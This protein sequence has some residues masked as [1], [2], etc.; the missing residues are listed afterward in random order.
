MQNRVVNFLWA[1][2]TSV[3]ETV[4]YS[5]HDSILGKIMVAATEH[6]LSA[7]DFNVDK[8]QRQDHAIKGLMKKWPLAKLVES[9]GFTMRYAEQV[10]VMGDEPQP[11]TVHVFGSP[12]QQVVWQELAD[13][14]F[15]RT[16]TYQTIADNIGNP[17]AVRAVGSAVG[18]NPVAF[19]LPCHRVIRSDGEYGDYHWGKKLKHQILEWEQEQLQSY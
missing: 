16:V 4:Y 10:L 15:G 8:K 18:S 6:G 17:N 19:L 3:V 11:I 13:I 9:P 14:P 2:T 12:F 7:I 5:Q 1:N